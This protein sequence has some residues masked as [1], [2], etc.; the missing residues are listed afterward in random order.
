MTAAS[1][2]TFLRLQ[3]KHAMFCFRRGSEF[4]VTTSQRHPCPMAQTSICDAEARCRLLSEC[5]VSV[6]REQAGKTD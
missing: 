5:S 2:R 4:I 6:Q 1:H 3:V